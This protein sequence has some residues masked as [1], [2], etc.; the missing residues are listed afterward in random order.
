MTELPAPPDQPPES[1]NESRTDRGAQTLDPGALRSDAAVTGRA[2]SLSA[3]AVRTREHAGRRV[4]QLRTRN[5]LVDAAFRAGDL[6]RRR[7]GSLLSGGIAF[8]LFLWLLP[9]A[10]LV[11]GA[12]GL[13]QPSGSAQP[14]HVAHTLG[15]GASA[16]AIVRQATK[17]S[18]EAPQLCWR[19]ASH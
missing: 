8:R 12:I 14:D 3:R 13:V 11:A 16:V 2:R 5:E 19:S 18:H 4:E 15:L 1:A 10:L 17:Q 7:A 6:D 9:A